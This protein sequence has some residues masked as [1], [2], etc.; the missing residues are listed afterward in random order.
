MF[1][2]FFEKEICSTKVKKPAY[3]ALVKKDI[4]IF[5]VAK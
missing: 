2:P 1:K 4:T 3:A 5:A